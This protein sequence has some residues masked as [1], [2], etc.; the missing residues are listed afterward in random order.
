M[1]RNTRAIFAYLLSALIIMTSGTMAVARGHTMA[2]GQIVI[3][4]G[5]G[6][7]LITVDSDNQ[8]VGPVQYCPD[9]ALS[10]MDLVS[11]DAPSVQRPSHVLKTL[12]LASASTGQCQIFGVQQ[13][14]RA[15]PHSV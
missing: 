9:C 10:F 14:A 4:T 7:K 12:F 3:C 2:A 5:Y 11:G 8:P 15:P 1:K 6:M 13:Q